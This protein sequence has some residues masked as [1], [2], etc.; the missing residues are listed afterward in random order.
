MLDATADFKEKALDALICTGC[1]D[2]TKSQK[3]ILATDSATN[4]DTA[5]TN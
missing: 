2:A 4:L 3:T 1:D 5:E